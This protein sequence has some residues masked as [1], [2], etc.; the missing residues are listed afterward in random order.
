MEAEG[1]DFFLR[2]DEKNRA[3][4]KRSIK[5]SVELI[6]LVLTAKIADRDALTY[7]RWRFLFVG[8]INRHR[9]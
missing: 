7:Q 2:S 3:S 6:S 4:T 8:L 5:G 9:I 1:P